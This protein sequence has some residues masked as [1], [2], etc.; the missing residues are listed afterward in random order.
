M[1]TK[2]ISYKSLKTGNEYPYEEYS[3]HGK[4]GWHSAFVPNLGMV[5]KNDLPK[6][7]YPYTLTYQP[8]EVKVYSKVE[9]TIEKIFKEETK[10]LKAGFYYKLT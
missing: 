3:N 4:G 7:E 2:P 9:F 5:S 8:E 1:D 6:D 10:E